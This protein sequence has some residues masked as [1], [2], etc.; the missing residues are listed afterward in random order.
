ME[1]PKAPVETIVSMK[2]TKTPRKPRKDKIVPVF[3]IIQGPT[4]VSFK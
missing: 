2:K 3:K 1:T 4:F